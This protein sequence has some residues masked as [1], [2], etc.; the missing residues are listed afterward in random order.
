M[1][2]CINCG[3][4]DKFY[5]VVKEQGNALIFQNVQSGVEPV[6]ERQLAGAICGSGPT[7]PL[8]GPDN[9]VR[10]NLW[11]IQNNGKG[12]EVT[13]AYLA[14]EGSWKGFHEVRSCAVCYSTDITSI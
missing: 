11:A 4:E 10:G 2:K 3:N 9:T 8:P 5:G 7:S 13:W 14:S 1:Y 12:D 6:P